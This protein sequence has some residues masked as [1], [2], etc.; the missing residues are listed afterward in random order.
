MSEVIVNLSQA[1]IDGLNTINQL[2]SNQNSS[3]DYLVNELIMLNYNLNNK[4]YYYSSYSSTS[5]S[6]T[7]RYYDGTTT[8]FTGSPEN[9]NSP[10]GY[11]NITQETRSIPGVLTET[12]LGNFTYGYTTFGGLSFYPISG[13]TTYSGIS[14]MQSDPN[15]GQV[16]VNMSGSIYSDYATHQFSGILS[17]I[18][19]TATELISS[20][21]IAGNFNIIGNTQVVAAGGSVA[22]TGVIHSIS[23]NFLDG[24][25]FLLTGNFNYDGSQNLDIDNLLS[26]GATFSGDD[27]ITISLPETVYQNILLATG[28]GNDT[29]SICGGGPNLNVNSGSGNDLINVSDFGHAIDGGNGDDA[30]VFSNMASSYKITQL[31]TNIVITTGVNQYDVDTLT[32]VDL[33]KFS[34]QSFQTKWFSE[35]QA[36]AQT[37]ASEF[38]TITEMYIAYFNRAPD[39]VGLDYWA[40][41]IYEGQNDLQVAHSFSIS[42]EAVNTYGTI[43]ANSS[44]NAITTFV[45]GVYQNVLNRTP[46]NAGLDYWVRQ[47]HGGEMSA[48]VF[49]LAVINAVNAEK[50]TDIDYVYLNNKEAVGAHFAVTNGLTDSIQ[51]HNVI[52]TYNSTYIDSGATTAVAA[53][54]ALSDGY[55]D[56]VSTTPEL[57]VQLIGVIV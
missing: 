51:A 30:C 49:I 57:L 16:G 37:N 47:L 25:H 50:T 48:D 33:I 10:S 42:Q 38:K 52:N 1:D 29:I 4:Y 15:F 27:T 20:E 13:T 35:A 21:S 53:S 56:H 44:L 9:L 45:N 28:D 12:T 22:I 19:F 34:D 36:L 18:T 23:E 26:D 32:N 39:A 6:I 14:L 5:S 43:S 11:V 2:D 55:L 40:S 7:L 31:G 24:G 17:N 54:N 8:T 3:L 41:N 46:D